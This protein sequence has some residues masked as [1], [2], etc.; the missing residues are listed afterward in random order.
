MTARVTMVSA[1]VA[2]L[3]A[4]L[5]GTAA[6]QTYPTRPVT[7]VVPGAAGG[8]GDFTARLVGEQ[9]SKALGQ[10]FVVENKPGAN[11]NL[12]ALTVA[13]AAPD[14]Y[15]LLL[16]YS[17][18]H[19]ANPALFKTIQWD[20][21]KSFT[22]VA[23]AIKAPHAIV[24]KKDL[25][26]ADLRA[27]VTY[28]KQNPGKINFGS[29]GPGSIQ[30]IGGERLAQLIDTKMVHVSYRGAAPAMNDLLSGSIELLITTPPSV[31]GHLRAG[32][33][34]GLAIASKVRHPM[35]A[36]LP[37]TAEAG[38]P[39]FELDAWFGIYAPAG[40]PQPVVDRLAAE[41]ETIVRSEDFKRRAEDSGTYAV[42]LSPAE[43]A[44]FTRT[45]LVYWSNMIKQLG[46]SLD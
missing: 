41:I 39:G 43:L 19:V 35:L 31:V 3:V 20:P 7:I 15:T 6:A 34:K 13:R 11:G 40:T 45:E 36:D 8:G 44:E 23:L 9:L 22:P 4:A 37:T 2:A 10:Q 26:A 24:V 27:F 17:G 32:S 16:A 29:S 21:I 18:S 30:H 33:V 14:G 28:A 5:P 1:A 12:A 42:Y 25:P 38:L 46:I